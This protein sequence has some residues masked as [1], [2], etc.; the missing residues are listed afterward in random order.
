M[1]DREQTRIV[2]FFFL[3]WHQ[4]ELVLQTLI[5]ELGDPAAVLAKAIEPPPPQ[6]LVRECCSLSTTLRL[7]LQQLLALCESRMHSKQCKAAA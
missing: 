2:P 6:M 1:N 4:E 3:L 7:H 5:L